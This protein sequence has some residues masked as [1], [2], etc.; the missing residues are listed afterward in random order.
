MGPA[1]KQSQR[2]RWVV[3]LMRWVTHD[4]QRFAR[5]MSYAPLPDEL[6]EPAEAKI[7]SIRP[8]Q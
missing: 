3:E 6:V 1:I 5:S 2:P 4:G 8:V 7:T